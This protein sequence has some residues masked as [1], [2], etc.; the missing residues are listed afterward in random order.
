MSAHAP[1]PI[2]TIRLFGDNLTPDDVDSV[3]GGNRTSAASKGGILVQKP[4]RLPVKARTGTWF[5][6]SKGRELD[7]P[8]GHLG[9]LID[10][11]GPFQKTL[12]RKI[13]G[14]KVELSIIVHDE[15]FHPSDLSPRILHEATNLGDLEIEAPEA[16][17]EWV[18][19]RSN[20]AQFLK[21]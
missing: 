1:A 18:L 5:L 20:V 13:P 10:R 7:G 3:L 4:G 11:V 17:Q 14:M 21:H 6:T 19:T 16:N 2:A 12:K 8:E 15:A 9:W